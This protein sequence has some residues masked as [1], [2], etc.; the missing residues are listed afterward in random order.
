M[1]KQNIATND[2]PKL[3]GRNLRAEKNR[4][5]VAEAFLK[6]LV[7]GE[8][9]P[10]A[11]MISKRSGVS[12]STLFRLY[13]D[14]E[15]IHIAVLND[16]VEQ[17][18]EYFVDVPIQLPL[19]ERVRQLVRLRSSYYEKVSNVRRYAV[20]RRRVSKLVDNLL[21]K[22]EKWFYSQVQRLFAAEMSELEQA[23]D[24]LLGID[25]ITSWESWERLRT[26]QKLSVKRAKAVVEATLMRLLG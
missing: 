12:T 20:A 9:H 21:S 25:N 4:K 6:L 17:L 5:L 14:L 15:A 26:V 18:R 10:T 22:N 23:A 13:E 16:R 8:S 19:S 3:D 2:K 11:Q 24:V 7:D 1:S